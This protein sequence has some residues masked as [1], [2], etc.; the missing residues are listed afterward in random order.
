MD[1]NSMHYQG[2]SKILGKLDRI[3]VGPLCLKRNAFDIPRDQASSPSA[4][5]STCLE[6]SPSSEA[7]SPTSVDLPNSSGMSASWTGS[8][9]GDDD[10]T[11]G[12]RANAYSYGN[13]EEW[14]KWDNAARAKKAN[15]V[16]RSPSTQLMGEEASPLL[17]RHPRASTQS[18]SAG[19][20]PFDQATSSIDPASLSA[21]D[22]SPYNFGARTAR[23]MPFTF[24][25]AL[26]P[27]STEQV[28]QQDA[29][30]PTTLSWSQSGNWDF[31]PGVEIAPLS[32]EQQ[33]HLRNIAFPPRDSKV[34]RDSPASAARTNKSESESPEPSPKFSSKKRKSHPD[35]DHTESDLAPK[36]VRQPPVKKTAHNM[37]EKRYR[38]NLNDKIAALRDSVPSL[39]HISRGSTGNAD[40]DDA[41]D[42]D[43]LSPA[44]KLNKATVLSKATEY[45]RH[46]EKTNSQLIKE[47]DV[48]M[49]R[50]NA[51]ETLA[52]S[53]SLGI[54]TNLSGT[55]NE[56]R[57]Q[58]APFADASEDAQTAGT[59]GAPQGVIQ[60]PESMTRL[61]TGQF[62]Q[63]YTNKQPGYH[64][65]QAPQPRPPDPG[66]Q[67]RTEGNGRGGGGVMSKLMVGSLAGMMVLEGFSENEQSNETPGGRGLSALPLELFNTFTGHS[68]LHR[69]SRFSVLSTS[70]PLHGLIMLLKI[71]LVFGALIYILSPSFFDSKQKRGKQLAPVTHLRAA[72][73]LA[74]PIEDRRRAWLTAIQ[75][76]WVPRHNLILEIAALCLKTLKLSV[77]NLIGWQGYAALTGTTKEDEIARVKA[78]GIALDAQL[79]GGDAE[80]NKSRLTLTLMASGTLPA[81][82]S[83]LMLKAIHIRVLLWE[84][85]NAGYGSWYMFEEIAAKLARDQWNEARRLHKM[86]TAASIQEIE[87]FETLP[88]HLSALLELDCDE[89]LVGR[90]IHRAYNL[91]WN[92]STTDDTS[93][94]QSGTDIVV[95]DSAIRSPLDAV[96]AW[97]STG[98]LRRALVLHM[99]ELGDEKSKLEEDLELAL[100][101]AP[102]AS[103]AQARALLAKNLLIASGRTE[104][105]STVLDLM[106]ADVSR[107]SSPIGSSTSN[108]VFINAT[109][110]SLASDD[111]RVTLQCAI[112][113]ALP[114]GP[115]WDATK[116]AKVTTVLNNL[117]VHSPAVGLLGFVSAVQLQDS[118]TEGANLPSQLEDGLEQLAGS[119]RVWIGGES[120]RLSGLS[121]VTRA[122]L[123]ERCLNVSRKAVG[124]AEMPEEMDAGYASLSEAESPK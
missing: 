121:K 6:S 110:P 56:F 17:D 57:Y 102:P 23:S 3:A 84:V 58:Q 41:E 26:I 88:D 108:A 51:F 119:L 54:N 97:W 24:N 77:R 55:T 11:E 30:Y 71:S 44:H 107:P 114:C 7:P 52:M 96:S 18:S 104:S 12:T 124:M 69:S 115:P 90:I 101:T 22:D 80:I 9:P 75:T 117:D 16:R 63:H 65:F 43:G 73:S 31:E 36:G 83:R 59:H 15:E 105:L 33:Q 50:L 120:G 87:S 14:M 76:V 66:N 111:L 35:Q 40:E 70:L 93:D 103:G 39:R 28:M 82:P 19:P 106:P 86:A 37:I 32:L 38:T 62:Q 4:T 92:R 64:G 8:V 122:K 42:L 109:N 68:A 116:V 20:A 79:T 10:A 13:W 94:V 29:F 89:V 85:A 47:K 53:G 112:S 72:P 78:W 98:L 81:T 27:R 100:K 67:H 118:L 25:D 61:H 48:L 60:V 34:F 49:T 45:I 21:I 46:L 74:S 95:E 91:A 5:S 113:L 99:E 2:C 123:V 1:P